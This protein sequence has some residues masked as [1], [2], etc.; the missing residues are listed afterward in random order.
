MFLTIRKYSGATSVDEAISRVEE[1]LVP[2]L[3]STSGFVAYYAIKYEDGDIGSVSVY[4]TQDNA[5][6]SG[7]GAVDWVRTNLGDLLP[8]EPKVFR[9]EVVVY[10]SAKAVSTAA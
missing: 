5:E 10:E 8:N 1:G 3:R 2:Y 7:A 4:D 6:A 9:G